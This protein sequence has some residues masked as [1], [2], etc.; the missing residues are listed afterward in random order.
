[1]NSRLSNNPGTYSGLATTL[2]RVIPDK[3]ILI[4]TSLF[5]LI[6]Y[7]LRK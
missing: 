3:H 7:L 4:A 1:M 2:L 6:I 5:Y